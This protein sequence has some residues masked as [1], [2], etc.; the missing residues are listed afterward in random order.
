[1]RAEIA[2]QSD[3]IGDCSLDFSHA[4]TAF[5][6]GGQMF[7]NFSDM[8]RRGL[9]IHGKQNF[10]VPQVFVIIRYSCNLHRRIPGA[11]VHETVKSIQRRGTSLECWLSRDSEALPRGGAD[12]IDPAPA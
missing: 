10:P 12:S 2:V 1:M 4:C 7:A 8:A 6:A 5:P 3:K 11:R 9:V